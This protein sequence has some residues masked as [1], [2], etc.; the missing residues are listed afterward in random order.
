MHFIWLVF[1]HQTREWILFSFAWHQADILAGFS[2]SINFS[3]PFV[4]SPGLWGLITVRGLFLK[5][6]SGDIEISLVQLWFFFIKVKEVCPLPR[7][8]DESAVTCLQCSLQWDLKR[9][10]EERRKAGRRLGVTLAA[11]EWTS[12]MCSIS[13]SQ[14]LHAEKNRI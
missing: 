4:Y 11:A 7:R 9:V 2:C 3:S 10:W 14:H 6:M 5:S 12:S 1:D 13:A 8:L